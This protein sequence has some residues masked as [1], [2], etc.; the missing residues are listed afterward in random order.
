M[1]VKSQ[2]PIFILGWLCV[3]AV[4]Y[5]VDVVNLVE[6]VTESGNTTHKVLLYNT[7]QVFSSLK[8]SDS[9]SMELQAKQFNFI[10][11]CIDTMLH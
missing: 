1:I 8:N 2:Y 5:D 6:G 9:L 3:K 11:L 4:V 7:L 10:W